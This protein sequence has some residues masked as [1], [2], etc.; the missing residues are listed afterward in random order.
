MSAAALLVV[1]AHIAVAGTAPQPDEGTAAHLWQ[2]LMAAQVPVIAF[3]AIRW[4]PRSA[5]PALL[6]LALQIGAAL[7][8]AAPV[9]LL[10]L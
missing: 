9:F 8:A 5:R 3:F 6:V 4:L 2:L 7:A 1:L 10:G